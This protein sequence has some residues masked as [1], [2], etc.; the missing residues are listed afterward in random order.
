MPV[1]NKCK[2]R[3]CIFETGSRWEW[4]LYVVSLCGRWHRYAYDDEKYSL[5]GRQPLGHAKLMPMRSWSYNVLLR[6]FIGATLSSNTEKFNARAQIHSK[7]V[8]AAIEAK[9]LAHLY[10]YCEHLTGAR[11]HCGVVSVLL[12]VVCLV[13]C[14]RDLCVEYVTCHTSWLSHYR[15]VPLFQRVCL[16]VRKKIALM[17]EV[18]QSCFVL[19]LKRM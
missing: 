15:Y 12:Q 2:I 8:P 16:V 10:V 18:G 6:Y 11:S 5:A 9:R 17:R 1:V 4:L 19:F 3:G 14:L 7:C 13:N